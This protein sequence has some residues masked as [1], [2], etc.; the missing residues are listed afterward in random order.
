MRTSLSSS[1]KAALLPFLKKQI[2]QIDNKLISESVFFIIEISKE[3][4]LIVLENAYCP[5]R[6]KKEEIIKLVGEKDYKACVE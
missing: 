1:E 4:S 3:E 5:F 2:L 6:G